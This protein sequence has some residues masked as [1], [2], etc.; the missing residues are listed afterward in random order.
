MRSQAQRRQYGEPVMAAAPEYS[1]RAKAHPRNRSRVREHQVLAV[2]YSYSAGACPA[3]ILATKS[4][5]SNSE[6]STHNAV[7]AD[8]GLST[9]GRRSTS[10]GRAA[11]QIDRRTPRGPGSGTIDHH[12]TALAA[13]RQ[14]VRRTGGGSA[15]IVPWSP[16]PELGPSCLVFLGSR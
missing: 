7:A 5:A 6:R 1:L 8:K 12:V 3:S 10:R 13:E 4:R 9:L 15:P 11:F 16:C 2:A 14:G